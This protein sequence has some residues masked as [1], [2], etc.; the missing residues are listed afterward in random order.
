MA[1][2]LHYFNYKKAKPPQDEAD[3]KEPDA[4]VLNEETEKFLERVTSSAEE[5]PEL[6]RRHTIITEDGKEIKGKDAQIALMNGANEI[7][8]PL[9]P[10][11]G[12]DSAEETEEETGSEKKE[13]ELE[14][15]DKKRKAKD[16]WSYVPAVPWRSSKVGATVVLSLLS[17]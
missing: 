1:G 17:Y 15:K 2:V 5:R 7:P 16:Y 13:G 9:S 3:K 4:P 14:K 8:L 12:E 11:E 6:P 10:G